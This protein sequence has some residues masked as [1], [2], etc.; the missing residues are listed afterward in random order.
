MERR[1]RFF[2]ALRGRREDSMEFTGAGFSIGPVGEEHAE[3]ILAVY[4]QCE[5]FL[6]LG[7]V[8]TASLEMV[9]EDLRHSREMGG[10]FCG[11]YLGGELAGVVDF[12]PDGFEG[13]RGA[14]F[15]SLLMIAQKHRGGGLGRAVVR[16]VEAEMLKN[17]QVC[18]IRSG[19]QVNNAP[20]IRFWQAMGYGVDGGPEL[21]PD[22]TVCYSLRKDVK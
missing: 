18:V 5:D 22:R 8:A 1:E 21:L 4:R 12:V 14:A 19:V 7:P 9:R 2:D 16:A 3:A 15:L 13:E 11:I 17:P 20:A 10:Q 6:A